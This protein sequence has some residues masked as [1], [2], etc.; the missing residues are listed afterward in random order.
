MRFPKMILL[1]CAVPLL[2]MTACTGATGSVSSAGSVVAHANGR[3]EQASAAYYATKPMIDL[4]VA[5]LPPTYAA[6]ITAAQ[7]IV[8]DA[9]AAARIATTAAEQLIEL[10][11]VEAARRE[12]AALTGPT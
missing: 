6:R 4:L 11:K 12:I 8:E 1:A 5:V 2:A 7:A 9:L 3:V 10:R